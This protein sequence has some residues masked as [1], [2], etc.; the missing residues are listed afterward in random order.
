MA[1]VSFTRCANRRSS[2]ASGAPLLLLD[3]EELD[4]DELESE[5]EP[6]LDETVVVVPE[7]LV[8]LLLDEDPVEEDDVVADV[9]VAEVD[10]AA[11][12]EV[13]PPDEEAVL[14]DEDEDVEAALVDAALVLAELEDA[15]R[16]ELTPFPVESPSRH[17]PS[18]QRARSG[19]S[20]SLLHGSKHSPSRRI[21]PD[22]HSTHP[23]SAA[24]S[25][26]IPSNNA[27]RHRANASSRAS[28]RA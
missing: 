1:T 25:T 17:T 18:T 28:A 16:L 5:D 11:L 12:A 14:E 20:P 24:A 3:D 2:H 23:D 13:L 22:A 19:H 8:A 9:E 27:T 4:D 7:L 15:P 6:L 26:P 21:C 10:A